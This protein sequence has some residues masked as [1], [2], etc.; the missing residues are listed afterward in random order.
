MT[1]V[2]TRKDLTFAVVL[3][4][5]DDDEKKAAYFRQAENGRYMRMAIILKLLDKK[6]LECAS[7]ET[8]S[9]IED[10][11]LKCKNDRCITS[12]ERGIKQFVTRCSDGKIRCK[13]CEHEIKS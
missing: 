13:Y 2:R 10:S 11:T 5:K 7:K 1:A 9:M 4:G 8:D 6:S 3:S 12:V